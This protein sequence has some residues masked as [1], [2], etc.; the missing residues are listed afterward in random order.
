MVDGVWDMGKLMQGLL[1][2]QMHYRRTGATQFSRLQT[3]WSSTRQSTK[4]SMRSRHKE[5]KIESGGTKSEQA[6]SQNL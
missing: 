1:C 4:R 2:R 3:S 5:R 6:Y